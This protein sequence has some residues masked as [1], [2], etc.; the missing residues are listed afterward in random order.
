[1][2]PNANLKEMLERAQQIL[3]DED[4]K[5]DQR[6]HS[7]DAVRL[8]AVVLALNGWITNGGFLPSQ[9]K[10]AGKGYF[11]TLLPNTAAFFDNEGEL[12]DDDVQ[13]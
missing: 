9:W 3:D 12:L 2:D 6:V 10:R 5:P 11:S 4:E 13:T 8:A 7:A 1:M